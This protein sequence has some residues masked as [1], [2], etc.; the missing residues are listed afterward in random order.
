[1]IESY[2]MLKRDKRWVRHKRAK[3]LGC[4]RDLMAKSL[5]EDPFA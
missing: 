3:G 4:Q 2:D 1:M 5:L